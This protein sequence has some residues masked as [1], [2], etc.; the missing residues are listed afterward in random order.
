M[1]A[2]LLT[3]EPLTLGNVPRPRR[4]RDDGRRCSPATASPVDRAAD[5]RTVA[6]GGPIDNTEAPYDLVRKMRASVLVLGPLLARIG[7]ARVS[8]PGGCAIGTR[9]IDLHLKGL[10]Q[11]GATIEL[12]GGYVHASAPRGLVGATHRAAAPSASARPRTC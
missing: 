11:L 4:H 3:A 1:A 12:E 8:L 5:G 10:E 6:I 9:P 2:G 7:E